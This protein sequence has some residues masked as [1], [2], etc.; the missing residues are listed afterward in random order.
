MAHYIDRNILCQAYVHIKPVELDKDEYEI[1]KSQI[2]HFIDTRGRFF[3]YTDIESNVEL[4]EGSLKVYATLAGALY[5]GIGQYG[6]FRGGLEFLATDVKRLSESIVNECIFLS[7][8][9]HKNIIHVEARVGVVG[10]LKKIVD[11]LDFIEKEM[12]QL[13]ENQ[14]I[15]K[16]R[17]TKEEVARLLDN[18]KDP[19]DTPY[20]K[21]NLLDIVNACLPERPKMPHPKKI[22]SDTVAIYRSEREELFSLLNHK[23]NSKK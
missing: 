23:K 21:H 6:D 4:K 18:L 3:L 20:V 14:L 19:N 12:S 16:L 17:R 15:K 11:D 22:N 8:S 7:K 10:S 13:E 1:F 2:D 5:L 9:R